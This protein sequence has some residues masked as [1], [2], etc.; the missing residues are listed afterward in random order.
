MIPPRAAPR[1]AFAPAKDSGLL[2]LVDATVTVMNDLIVVLG[3]EINLLKKQNIPAIQELMRRKGTLV[4]QYMANMK[5]LAAQA[6]LLKKLPKN[7]R[8]NL[9]AVGTKLA[10]VAARNASAL[11]AASV[12]TQ[13]LIQN[14][15]AAVRKEKLE[16]LG[17]KNPRT[18]HLMLGTYDKTCKPVAFTRTA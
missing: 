2:T 1:P 15:V 7:I 16:P 18:A 10:E 12:V 3:E 9:R 5:A 6:E 4:V 11:K 13:R 17:Y 8:D 14:I